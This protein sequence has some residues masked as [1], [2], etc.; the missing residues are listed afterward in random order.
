MAWLG[1]L[2]LGFVI[3]VIAGAWGTLAACGALAGDVDG[4]DG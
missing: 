4:Y 3:G 2:A 1:W